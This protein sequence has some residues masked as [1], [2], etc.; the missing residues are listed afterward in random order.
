MGVIHGLKQY[1]YGG[2]LTVVMPNGEFDLPYREDLLHR[3]L[4]NLNKN[5]KKWVQYKENEIVKE[6]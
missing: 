5:N 1:E 6:I 3:K 4:L 2:E